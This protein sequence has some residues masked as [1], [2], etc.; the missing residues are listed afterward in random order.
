MRP[1]QI[2]V[3][4]VAEKYL[5][6]DQR[7]ARAR[8]SLPAEYQFGDAGLIRRPDGAPMATADG[9]LIVKLPKRFESGRR[10]HLQPTPQWLI[11]DFVRAV[12]EAAK[13]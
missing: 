10:N 8:R 2:V 9:R 1:L 12:S 11:D 6:P 5:M 4:A 7:L 13:R 3:L